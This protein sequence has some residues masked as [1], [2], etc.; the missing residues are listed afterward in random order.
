MEGMRTFL[1]LGI[2]VAVAAQQAPRT[3]QADAPAA[4]A[5]AKPADVKTEPDPVVTKQEMRIGSRTL[6]YTATTG[7]MPMVNQQTGQTEA[8]MFFVAYTL[9][10]PTPKKQ[11]PLMI[12][13]NGGPG[14]ATVWLHLGMIGPKRVRMKDDGSYP[15][16]PFALEDN[17]HT[18]LEFADLV[19]V[20]PV[21]TGYSRAINPEVGK[22]FWNVDGDIASVGDFV[23]L[24]LTRY[25][26]WNSPLF[27]IG[28]SYG[29]FRAAG[30][31]GHLIDR[32]VAFNG[33]ILV[34]SILNF[35]TA[36][37]NKGND[38][39]YQLFLPTYAATAWYHKKVAPD[40][41]K[42]LKKTLKEAEDYASGD[43]ALALAK[44]DRITPAERTAAIDKLHRLTGL[45]KRWLDQNDL[46]IEIMRFI[47]E[48]RRAEGKTVGRLDSR[49]EGVEGLNG[50]EMPQ[51]DPSM[52]AIRPPYTA[53]FID[54]S[55]GQL[56]Y[57]SDLDY[58]VLGGGI[59]AWEYGA[60]GR[61]AYAD[62]SDAL[63][64]A[65]AKNPYMRVFI[66]SGYYDLATPY[67][68]T[69]YTFSHMGLPTRF[70][71]HITKSYFDAG[72]MFYSHVPSLERVS[73]EIGEFVRKSIPDAK[74]ATGGQ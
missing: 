50:S 15:Q 18:F 49:L 12:A 63:R 37:F 33:V 68:A 48:L 25:E 60:G 66:G 67:F 46:R 62:T 69:E 59:G 26:R 2:A 4:P 55:R 34:S 36:R 72:H 56:N 27:V 38:L 17:A 39:P 57:K 35:Q 19:F 24:Y 9:D 5:A 28:E 16:P 71:E 31:A 11:R 23:R 65:F 43:Y 3:Q 14:A 74:A 21:G 52:T 8:H 53:L 64:Q 29:T 40:L 70:K 54:Y 41:Q 45:E 51:F 30:L 58:Y 6:S 42:D 20:D 22:K 47:K 73:K 13:F 32:G 44:G 10:G 7:R 1:L 61:N